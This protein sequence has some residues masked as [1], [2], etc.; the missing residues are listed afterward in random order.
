MDGLE[1]GGN[2]KSKWGAENLEGTKDA[3]NKSIQVQ[4]YSRLQDQ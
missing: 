2:A 1:Q 4:K 3:S